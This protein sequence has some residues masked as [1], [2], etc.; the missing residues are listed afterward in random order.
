[1]IPHSRPTISEEDISHVG[2]NLRTGLIAYGDEVRRFEQDLSEYIGVRGGVATNS[3]TNALYLALTAL[4]IRPGDEVIMPSYVCVSVL[5]SVKYAG[6]SPVF[7]DIEQKS[8]NIDSGFVA[9]KITSKTKAIIVPHLFGAAADLDQLSTFGI[10]IIEDCAQAIGAEYKGRKLGSYGL[11]STFSFK[12]TK[13]I[14]TGHGGMVMTNSEEMLH[15]LRNFLKYDQ[16]EKY[17][18]SYNYHLTDF[19]AAMGRSQLN[20]LDRFIERRRQISKTYSDVF[21]TLG[22]QVRHNNNGIFFRYVVEVDDSIEYARSMKSRGVCCEKPIFK[23]LHQ[24]VAPKEKLPNTE[25]AMSSALSI[26]IYPT[27]SNDEI[28]LVCTA[29]EKVWHKQDGKYRIKN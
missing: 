29:I 20:Q 1:M 22:H 10:P 18:I 24:Y 6:A 3:G 27:L 16:L 17:Q 21:E 14:T 28:S 19:Q 2:N 23:P 15:K 5:H 12:A 11:L 4:D 9:K 7:A 26:P 25:R 13:L 8:Y